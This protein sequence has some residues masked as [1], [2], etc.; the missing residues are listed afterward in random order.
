M[1]RASATVG[2]VEFREAQAGDAAAVAAL[3][4][5]SWR[6][7][8]R[9]SFSDAF[10]DGDLLGERLEVWRER[11]DRPPPEQHV[12]LACEAGRLLGFV[13]VHGAHDAAWGSFVDNLHVAAAAKRRGIG[14]ELMRRAGAWLA[15]RHPGLGVYLLVLERNTAARRFYERLGGRCA[16]TA[17]MQTHGGATVRSCRYVW[18]GA[19][20]LAGA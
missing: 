20:R 17:T 9:G 8:Y 18:P 12:L 10:L 15:G 11:L 13:C 6:A 1:R 2:G 7:S 4:A 5:E 19:E 16:E 3:H 14:S